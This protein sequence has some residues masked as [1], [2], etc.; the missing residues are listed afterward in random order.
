MVLL[1]GHLDPIRLRDLAEPLQ[2]RTISQSRREIAETSHYKALLSQKLR[3]FGL[4]T[5]LTVPKSTSEKASR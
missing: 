2:E 5:Q 3:K 1:A 4:E